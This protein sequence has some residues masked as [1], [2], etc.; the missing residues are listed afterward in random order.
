MFTF[1]TGIRHSFLEYRTGHPGLV[2]SAIIIVLV[3]GS[4]FIGHW[5]GKALRVA[6][7]GWKFGVILFAILASVVVI[8]LGWPPRLGVD[9][10]G[11]SILVY[12][13]DKTK[14]E[15]RPE[16][17]DSLLASISRRVNPGGQKEISVKSLGTD[18]VEIIMP[19]VSGSTAEEKEAEAEEIRKIIRTTGALEF[20]IVATRRLNES[21]I[22]TAQAERRKYPADP[23]KTIVI[24]DSQGRELAK[25][26]PI[27]PEEV[28]SPKN[29]L[30][31]DE[32]AI[33]VGRVPALDKNGK[34]ILD[35]E[36]KPT[37]RERWEMLVL[38]PESEALTVT[39]ADVRDAHRGLD[40][41]TA[42]PQ[43]D[44]S[45]NALGG[46]KF[47]RFT[48]EYVPV[49]GF[50]YK[51]AIVLDDVLQTAP[52][53]KSAIS[54][55]GR[56]T[57]T[58]TEKEVDDIVEIINAGSLPAALEAEPV[59]DMT[60]SATLGAETIR[61]STVAMIIASI[62]VPLFMLFYYRFAGLVAVLVLS[63]NMLMLV[64]LMILIKAPFT[65]PALAG[66]ALTV[67]MA[68]DNNV[69]IYERLREEISHGAA[70]RMA[71]RNAFHRVGVVII[72]AN[73]THLIAATVLWSVG[74]EQI[75]GFAVTFWLG[76]ILSIWATM[77]VARAIFEVSERRRWVQR[78]D[79]M[80][81]IGHTKI[82]FMAWFPACA[83]FSVVITVLGLVIAVV[84]GQ[85]LFDIDFTGGVS[86]QTVFQ[87]KQDIE[88]VREQLGVKGLESVYPELGAKEREKLLPDITVTPAHS[89]DEPDDQRFIID[90]SNSKNEEVKNTLKKV[91]DYY[92]E[93]LVTLE[94]KAAA[95]AQ[96]KPTPPEKPAPP[97]TGKPGQ[98]GATW[99]E[100]KPSE[101]PVDMSEKK[102]A[103]TKPAE[104][105]KPEPAGPTKPAG[106]TKPAETTKPAES[107]PAETKPAETT[108]PAES[109]PAETSKPAEAAPAATKPADSKPK[110]S[111]F[112][113]P[114]LSLV[115]M[116]GE[117]AVLLAQ[118]D[119]ASLKATAEPKSEA[120]SDEKAS[121][122][123]ETKADAKPETKAD[124]KPDT[125]ADAKPETK[126]DAK[127][128]TKADAKP[129]TKADAK[130]DA[131]ADAKPETKADAKPESKADA[132][133]ETKADA[134]PETKADAKSDAKA[135]AK[136]ERKA[137][138]KPG[139]KADAK[140][141]S[142]ADAKPDAKA[143]A[144][145]DAKSKPAAKVPT[146][147]TSARGTKVGSAVD[148]STPQQSFQA[149]LTLSS[150]VT[151]LVNGKSEQKV[152]P[153]R[154]DADRIKAVIEQAL[155]ENKI[156]V[157]QVAIQLTNSE[158]LT[159]AAQWDLKLAPSPE[160]ASA[161]TPARFQA[162][163]AALESK[164]SALPY[165]PIEDSIG[166]AVASDTKFWAVVAL[167]SSWSLIILYLWIRF[168]G[169]A[170]GLAAVIALIHDVLVMLGA[171]AFSSYLALIPGLSWATAIEPFKINLPIVAAFLTIIGYSVNDT[172]VVFDR[173]RE[174]R[175][176]SPTLTR[177]MVNDAT[178]QTLSRTL[179]TS[180]T[181]MMVVVILYIW[182]GQAVHGFAFA[183]II[184]VLTGTYS[185]I[186]VAAPI[187]LWLLHPKEMKAPSDL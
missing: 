73:I 32:A 1:I 122:K 88:K 114:A 182:G 176:K 16:K 125:K 164:I 33:M 137:D 131:K 104:P 9:L 167:V 130:P 36:G 18:M 17:M 110:Q 8:V 100:D 111:R 127:P 132:K 28:D 162:V 118:A 178:N 165:F 67:G 163:L 79:M 23:G 181:V 83:T 74:T 37:D 13:V 141:E 128:D 71:I 145:P 112:D 123:P 15:W 54:D 5:L 48:G 7:Y 135:D 42:L 72:D 139:T 177:Q 51:L 38:A 26:V 133:P 64:A 89:Q 90:T 6:D 152:E 43:V 14:T 148:Y 93:R 57:G 179:L 115:A 180:L 92:Q 50:E 186:Y 183:L 185:S 47:G 91:F 117:E 126:A 82:D 155:E 46:A 156:P 80:Q 102:P 52:H 101:P 169:V 39:G 113:L 76:A 44:F 69:L 10:G 116:A 154:Y 61:Q 40:Q 96:E 85:G 68:V 94:L 168:Q 41:E 173:I 86:V 30:K 159:K 70:L 49:G 187:L 98:K 78:L 147:K 60:V 143:D 108:K 171:I 11:G 35:K 99:P 160:A 65:L 166:S 175:G 124:A 19:S 158:G 22:E 25:W 106:L 174:I 31:G 161:L 142:K 184:G 120:K 45:F 150:T 109:K 146:E 157:K 21:L 24:R 20:R 153:V 136:P 151:K 56:I 2:N 66:L 77:F 149:T 84:R 34:P 63:L 62:A 75:K 87:D 103:E 107:K 134:K 58:F 29:S 27:R 53:L 97:A 119:S 59:R 121:A 55:A 172:I 81:W 170:F 129:E 95:V 4:G 144:K 138:A 12:Q 140:P 105:P 3:F